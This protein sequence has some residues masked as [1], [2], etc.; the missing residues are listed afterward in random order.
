MACLSLSELSS[1]ICFDADGMDS[2]KLLKYE[3]YMF[4][5]QREQKASLLPLWLDVKTFELIYV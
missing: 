2:V 1:D 3:I 4:T 5:L